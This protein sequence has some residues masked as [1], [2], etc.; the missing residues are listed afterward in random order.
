MAVPQQA[1]IQ[2]W[3]LEHTI[4]GHY[5]PEAYFGSAKEAEEALATIKA[6]MSTDWRVTERVMWMSAEDYF[7]VSTSHAARW[8]RQHSDPEYAEYQRLDKKFKG[9]WK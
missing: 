9:I 3:V 8:V 5:Q 2:L 6:Y 1:V 7:A 4:D